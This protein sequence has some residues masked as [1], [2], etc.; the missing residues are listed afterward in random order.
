[1]GCQ[2]AISDA[3]CA[4]RA[5]AGRYID[6]VVAIPRGAARDRRHMPRNSGT[7]TTIVDA[8]TE[9]NIPQRP[10]AARLLASLVAAGYEIERADVDKGKGHLNVRRPGATG[11]TLSMDRGSG[12]VRL[13]HPRAG[14]IAVLFGLADATSFAIADTDIAVISALVVALDDC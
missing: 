8:V 11:R 6:L 1:M 13:H 9:M 4:E 12:R 2:W 3:L 7:P 5:R 14:E 10:L